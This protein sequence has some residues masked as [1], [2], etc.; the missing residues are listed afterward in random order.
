MSGD[1]SSKEPAEQSVPTL[2]KAW[3]QAGHRSPSTPSSVAGV[4][5]LPGC[6]TI[7][8]ADIRTVVGK[9]GLCLKHFQAVSEAAQHIVTPMKGLA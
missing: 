7:T 5:T 1:R 9:Y 3:R 6:V 4:C 8:F 2:A